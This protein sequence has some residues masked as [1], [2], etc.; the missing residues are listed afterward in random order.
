[1]ACQPRTRGT[2]ERLEYLREFE[3]QVGRLLNYTAEIDHGG[4]FILQ[5]LREEPDV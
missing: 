5:P 1:M 2:D 4:Y 3:E